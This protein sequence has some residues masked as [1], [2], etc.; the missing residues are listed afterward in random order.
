MKLSFRAK[1][2]WL[3]VAAVVAALVIW[4][5][6]YWAPPLRDAS[7]KRLPKAEGQIVELTAVPINGAKQ[8]ITVRAQNKDAPVLLFLHGGPGSPETTLL[9]KTFGGTLE[10][11]FVV[12][13]WDQRGAGKSFAAAKGKTLTIDQMVADT[14]NLV[15]YLRARFGKNKVFIV[16]HSW[17]S[18]LG[19]LFTA[20]Y[21]DRV[22]AYCGI[23]QLVSGM[24][25][26]KESY[27]WALAQAKSRGDAKGI[28]ALEA[29]AAYGDDPSAAGWDKAIMIERNW[30][31]VYGGATGHDPSFMGKMVSSV[32]F[33]PE[34]S[35]W[36]TIN[37]VRGNMK[38]LTDMWQ[39]ILLQDLR[40][41]VT[42][43]EV[44]V[45]VA[46]GRWD[47]NTPCTLAETYFNALEAPRKKLVWFENSAH[48]PCFEESA[49]FAEELTAFFLEGK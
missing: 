6:V 47:Y 2:I 5:F 49:K 3:A 10:R 4:S 11:D 27:R 40:V 9:S 34:Y 12:V 36:D 25:N 37:Y 13:T 18:L 28:K 22:A 23:G 45:M 19:T 16:G 26:E 8:W 42:S 24:E 33:A 30:L 35:F 41:S 44:P 1:V 46:A 39:S 15:D 38:G 17:G 43:L 7:G 29:I 32:V 21:P 31:N 48:S 14:L 20:R